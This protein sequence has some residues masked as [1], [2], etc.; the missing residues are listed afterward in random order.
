MG[1]VCNIQSKNRVLNSLMEKLGPTEGFKLY[2]EQKEVQGKSDA[3]IES[4]YLQ[5]NLQQSAESLDSLP[6]S[7]YSDRGENAL[8][9]SFEDSIGLSNWVQDGGTRLREYKSM[10]ERELALTMEEVQ[11][12]LESTGL[13]NN[14]KVVRAVTRDLGSFTLKVVPKDSVDELVPNAE[15]PFVD[16][17]RRQA[18]E[19][20]KEKMELKRER[21]SENLTET[22]EK[23]I[24][25]RIEELDILLERNRALIKQYRDSFTASTVLKQLAGDVMFMDKFLAQETFSY[26]DIRKAVE[27]LEIWRAASEFPVNGKHPFLDE[28]EIKNKALLKDF[29]DQTRAFYESYVDDIMERRDQAIV[30]FTRTNTMSESLTDAQILEIAQDTNMLREQFLNIGQ[31]VSPIVQAVF[32]SVTKANVKFQQQAQEDLDGLLEL[33]KIVPKDLLDKMYQVD[34]QGRYTGRLVGPYTAEYYSQRDAVLSRVAAATREIEEA[35]DSIYD[36]RFNFLKKVQQEAFRD[37]AKWYKDNHRNLTPVGVIQDEDT[38]GIIPAEYID[39]TAVDDDSESILMDQLVES[40]GKRQAEYIL[41]SM[42]RKTKQ[43]Q[44]ARE[45]KYMEYLGA[46]TPEQGLDEEGKKL[47]E[48]WLQQH[49]P[50]R[51]LQKGY[52]TTTRKDPDGYTITSYPKYKFIES[53]PNPSNEAFY[54]TNYQEIQSDENATKLYDMF[55]TFMSQGRDSLGD[56]DGFLTGLSIP[57]LEEKLLTQMMEENGLLAA[58]SYIADNIKKALRETNSEAFQNRKI[59]PAT[60]KEIKTVNISNIS[61]SLIKK[62]VALKY[63]ELLKEYKED[64][65]EEKITGDIKKN[66]RKN[67]MDEVYRNSATNIIG[68]MAYYRVNTLMA[69]H[70]RAL[71]PQVSIVKS[72]IADQEVEA[73]AISGQGFVDSALKRPPQE[74][75]QAT[76][77]MNA[78]DNF[79]DQKLYGLPTS[80]KGVTL[81]FKSYTTEEKKKLEIITDAI[82]TAQ[83]RLEELQ[84]KL[85]SGI[86]LTTEEDTEFDKLE[87]RIR[88]LNSQHEAIGG[89]LSINKLADGLIRF[90]Q[91]LG[92]GLSVPSAV[93]NTGFGYMA[94]MIEASKGRDLT[95]QSLVRAYSLIPKS[96]NALSPERLEIARNI[97]NIAQEYGIGA[98]PIEQKPSTKYAKFGKKNIFGKVRKGKT[99]EESAYVMM[100]ETEYYNQASLMSAIMMDTKVILKDGTET[101]FFE[102]KTNKDLSVED[103]Q[104]Y[105]PAGADNFMPFD[106]AQYVVYIK[107][108]AHRVHGDYENKTVIKNTLLGR[109]LSQYRT[110]MY[111]TVADRFDSERYD[112]LGGYT[113]KGRYRS[114]VPVGMVPFVNMFLP[115]LVTALTK[116]QKKL[117]KEISS[118]QTFGRVTGNSLG[119]AKT[120]AA[121]MLKNPFKFQKIMKEQLMEDYEKVDAENIVSVYAEWMMYMTVA[122]MSKLMLLAAQQAFGDDDDDDELTVAKGST[123]FA[124]NML[125]RFQNDL[126]FYLNPL[127][128]GRLVDNP[129]PAAYLQ[130]KATKL[131]DSIGRVLDD[132][133]LEVQSGIYE[134]WWWPTR[135]AIKLIPGLTGIDKIYRNMSADLSTGKKVVGDFTVFSEGDLLDKALGI[136]EK[137]ED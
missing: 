68:A 103:V 137:E 132:R 38:A 50:Y 14:Y 84:D 91:V 111:R 114:A 78:L 46:R 3:A 72:Y 54:D 22:R 107:N 47:F 26:D 122:L 29:L 32:A 9:E 93:A 13:S 102:V 87:E 19:F 112:A 75:G 115:P 101:S 126:T 6:T 104:S 113:T 86:N 10:G 60:N 85:N 1:K 128:A 21:S 135:D 59:N 95:T 23:Q 124:L 129:I 79:L 120:F 28:A 33:A 11:K 67:A 117:P 49:S 2:Y 43:F 136:D 125:S 80:K 66:L 65:P 83:K 64:N 8:I 99:L 62:Q 109:M 15:V 7:I 30:H 51:I 105:K 39:N 76:R 134:G 24:L 53:I 119:T 31:S 92:I 20:S 56:I 98:T 41:K 70:R 97:R 55:R 131:F 96:L 16:Q 127:E 123:I 34:E 40:V 81:P 27:K 110:W 63:E 4:I 82:N 74:K 44:A 71:E 36:K 61:D 45:S 35:P 18:Q 133:P 130:E 73:G 118:K 88:Y 17:L 12:E 5:E 69:A 89:K 121:S 57:L 116:D 42:K 52:R 48:F 106:E 58:G 25:N 108:V 100:E 90:N 77:T 94:N 37:Q